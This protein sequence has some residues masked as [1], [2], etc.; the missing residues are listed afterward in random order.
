[1]SF[2]SAVQGEGGGLRGQ[3]NGCGCWVVGEVRAIS[4]RAGDVSS[5][6]SVCPLLHL[7]V[8]TE[9]S[10]PPLS[11]TR[12]P[13]GVAESSGKLH[14]AEEGRLPA[15][16]SS[17]LIHQS[18]SFVNRRLKFRPP[19][20]VSSVIQSSYTA[21]VYNPLLHTSPFHPLSHPPALLPNPPRQLK[22]KRTK[23]HHHRTKSPT[24]LRSPVRSE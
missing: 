21:Y 7:G 1:M 12:C 5:H 20:L 19:P 2:S 8:L 24:A 18:L 3:I 22:T 9:A 23:H 13:L 17:H 14:G 11:C 16:Q 15:S 10:H 4:V 6:S